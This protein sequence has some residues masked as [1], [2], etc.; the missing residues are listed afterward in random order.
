MLRSL[1]SLLAATG[2][3]LMSANA[4][5]SEARAGDQ[6]ESREHFIEANGVRLRIWEKD[7][8]A[9]SRYG[10]VILA[11][12]SATAGEESFDL[13]VPGQPKDGE[14]SFSLMDTLAREG[15]DV[16]A[17]DI[18]GF[19]R[20]TKPDTGVTT[21]EAAADLDAVIDH[22]LKI[23]GAK[24]VSL[25]AWSWGTQYAG[26]EVIAHP[27]KIARYVSFAQ[28]H[29][30]SPD[31][32]KRRER[33][34]EFQMSPYMELPRDAWK[35]RFSA[36]TPERV[37][38]AAVIDAFAN[39]AFAIEKKT[40][41]GPQIDMTTRLPLVD[42][43]KITMP[44]LLI[45]GEFD[46]VADLAGLLPFFTALRS[47]EKSYIVVPDAGHMAQ[48]QAGRGRLQRAIAAFLKP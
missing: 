36:M 2:F 14:A 48:F 27:E 6:M 18:R 12:G 30:D 4:K 3:L 19:G 10:I 28:M 45:H 42:A 32:V 24:Q 44:T 26:L 47:P 33:L 7:D 41:T 40:P 35:K 22:V 13:Q 20:S 5:G 29:K 46:D 23:R 9:A 11:H 38:E 37:T 16:F 43:A 31:V 8:A 34:A 21:D 25:V 1:V 39:A 15:F 17:P